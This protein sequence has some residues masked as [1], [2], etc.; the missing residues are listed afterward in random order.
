MNSK[1]IA[2]V[3]YLTIIGWVIALLSHNNSSQKEPIAAFHLRQ[4]LGIMLTGLLIT[5][6]P[7][8]IGVAFAS[9]ITGI[10]M[11]VIWIIGFIS[12]VQGEE[13]EIPIV[14]KLYQDWFKGIN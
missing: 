11:V 2:I 8:F 10:V 14:G 4:S 9:R 12:A 5:A 13:K 7:P 1:N 6:V 3:S